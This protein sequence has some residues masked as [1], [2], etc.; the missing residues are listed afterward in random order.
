METLDEGDRLNGTIPTLDACDS[1]IPT[2]KVS[3]STIPTLEVSDSTIPTLEVSDSTVPTLEASNNQPLATE[4]S[5]IQG[6]FESS[7]TVLLR[8]PTGES[9]GE[10]QIPS[11][12]LAS[13]TDFTLSDTFRVSGK[14]CVV[15]LEEDHISWLPKKT[16]R[17]KEGMLCVRILFIAPLFCFTQ[18]GLVTSVPCVRVFVT[19]VKVESSD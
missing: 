11:F 17:K 6:V 3:D 16:T 7:T 2:L 1:T 8:R 18:Q 13:R 14:L 19:W 15:T 12:H 9:Q 4:T 10:R 5:G